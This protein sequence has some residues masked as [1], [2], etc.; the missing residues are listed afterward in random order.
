MIS[1]LFFHD[2]I[3]ALSFAQ[4]I[5]FVKLPFRESEARDHMITIPHTTLNHESSMTILLH[6]QLQ[7]LLKLM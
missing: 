1:Y 6:H 5:Q 7:A 4:S 2:Y 3:G